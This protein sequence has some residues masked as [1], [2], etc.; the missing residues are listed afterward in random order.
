MAA[1]K[2]A[3]KSKKTAKGKSKSTAGATIDNCTK[4]MKSAMARKS[5]AAN[6]SLGEIAAAGG[7]T[8]V[9]KQA[10]AAK[11]KKPAAKKKKPAAAAAPAAPAK[12]KPAKKKKSAAKKTKAIVLPSKARATNRVAKAAGMSSEDMKFVSALMA[13]EIKKLKSTGKRKPGAAKKKVVPL[14]K[15]KTPT[16][17]QA[18]E[19]LSRHFGITQK[20]FRAFME[21]A[22]NDPNYKNNPVRQNNPVDP[23]FFIHNPTFSA[24]QTT[25]AVVTTGVS[26]TVA[27]VVSRL[28]ATR[29]GDCKE[30]HYGAAASAR[31]VEKSGALRLG[32]DAVVAVGGFVGAYYAGKKGHVTAQAVLGGVATGFGIHG[33]YKVLFERIFPAIFKAEKPDD[34]TFGNRVMPELMDKD[35]EAL[36]KVIE[37]ANKACENASKSQQL[38]IVHR[39]HREH[40]L[41]KLGLKP[42]PEGKAPELPGRPAS[43]RLFPQ[44]TSTTAGVAGPVPGEPTARPRAAGTASLPFPRSAVPQPRAHTHSHA[45]GVEGC[46]SC[47]KGAGSVPTRRG[48]TT[49]SKPEWFNITSGVWYDALNQK[50]GNGRMDGAEKASALGAM[51]YR[52]SVDAF[53]DAQGRPVDLSAHLNLEKVEPTAAPAAVV[54]AAPAAVVAAAPAPAA[55]PLLVPEGHV[56]QLVTNRDG[57]RQVR[58]VPDTKAKPA[59]AP[60]AK[61]A[62][63]PNQDRL[64]ALLEAQG[65]ELKAQRDRFVALES[66][67]AIISAAPPPSIAAPVE[68]PTVLHVEQIEEKSAPQANTETPRSL[69]PRRSDK[70]ATRSPFG[71]KSN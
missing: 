58:F 24:G 64:V 40:L 61:P 65:E 63:S 42:A 66:K 54:A 41:A 60:E 32:V 47:G 50:V 48:G 30:A 2:P 35:Q 36:S 57:S 18:E 3:P 11:K 29:A 37:A 53:L 46:S 15:S 6:E 70:S 1:K 62:H 55:S 52:A 22:S 44:H 7:K 14:H 69:L 31:I 5:K 43:P 25:A 56:P 49:P 51:W 16:L 68:P 33:V 67:L 12:K 59:A 20:K 26:F 39:V 28:L 19:T 9:S 21:Q 23:R 34:K 38:Q 71:F 8:V 17:K 13:D 27:E 10:A 4:T 45:A